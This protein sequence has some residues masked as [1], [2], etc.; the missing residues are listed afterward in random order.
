MSTLTSI[1]NVFLTKVV[2]M[3]ARETA[4][5]SINGARKLDILAEK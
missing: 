2:D 3:H 1:D 4:V 5:F